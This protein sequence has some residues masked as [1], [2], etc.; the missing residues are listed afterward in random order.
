VLAL[1]AALD[2]ATEVKTVA[3]STSTGHEIAV[4]LNPAYHPVRLADLVNFD[5]EVALRP[6]SKS[7]TFDAVHFKPTQGW[8]V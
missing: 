1:T 5:G 4:S 8:Q 7:R 2:N 3:A 6:L